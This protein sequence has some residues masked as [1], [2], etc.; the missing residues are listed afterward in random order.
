MINSYKFFPTPCTEESRHI[1]TKPRI[2]TNMDYQVLFRKYRPQTFADVV[3]QTAVVTTLK[4]ALEHKRIANA[5]LFCGCRGTGKTTLARIFAKAINCESP[6]HGEPCNVC[7]SCEEITRGHSLDVIEIDGASNRGI[8]DIRELNDNVGYAP[9]GGRN[10]IFIIDE[11]HML[12]KEAFNALLKTL[13]EPPPNVKFFFAT[14]EPHKVLPTIISRCQ[15]FDLKRITISSIASKLS[16]ICHDLSITIED[17]ALNLI[18]RHGDGSMRDAESLL[19]QIICSIDQPIAGAAVSHILGIAPKTLFT[20]LDK[21]F[22]KGDL[23]EAFTIAHTVYASGYDIP[24]FLEGLAEHYRNILFTH[25]DTP[26]PELTAAE[27]ETYVHA[28]EIYTQEMCMAVL[29]YL[30]PWLQEVTKHAWKQVLLEMILL[31]ILRMRNILP[32]DTIVSRLEALQTTPSVD[33]VPQPEPP[34][35]K[36]PEAPPEKKDPITVSEHQKRERLLRFASVELNGS[37]KK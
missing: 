1:S 36:P 2:L 33:S 9:S 4:N 17:D 15:R 6:L 34:S 31:H 16:R 11:V 30:T 3:E 35:P 22:E 23:K 37:V 32:I 5:Y 18:A 14:T 21:A 12:T 24:H 26:L 25:I 13:E 10:K 29:E 19:D 27:K 20:R 7:S 28:K 8:D